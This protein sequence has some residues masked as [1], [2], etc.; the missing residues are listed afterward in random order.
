MGTTTKTRLPLQQNLVPS[1][2]L[3]ENALLSSRSAQRQCILSWPIQPLGI[4]DV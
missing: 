3:W 4:K 2:F 1:T